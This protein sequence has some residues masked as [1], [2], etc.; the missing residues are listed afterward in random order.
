MDD[1]ILP[2]FMDKLNESLD[3]ARYVIEETNKAGATGVWLAY[4][5]V[6]C[7][8]EALRELGEENHA[9][10]LIEWH[11]P[12]VQ[13]FYVTS[14]QAALEAKHAVIEAQLGRSTAALHRIRKLRDDLNSVK[15]SVEI[16]RIVDEQEL[17][18]RA[19]LHDFERMAE[20]VNRMPETPTV[21]I[22]H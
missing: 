17:I 7:A 19:L 22:G 10:A 14:W 16:F 2:E 6:Y 1:D 21:S 9:I 18:I 13:K 12:D 11:M 5:M 8:A 3:L 15:Y 20:L 4:D